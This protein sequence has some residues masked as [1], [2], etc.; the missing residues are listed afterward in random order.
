MFNCSAD[1]PMKTSRC[2]KAR[3][4]KLALLCTVCSLL[5]HVIAVVFVA[6]GSQVK[7][8][9]QVVEVAGS[10]PQAAEVSETANLSCTNI[11]EFHEFY[12]RTAWIS[13]A[14]IESWSNAAFSFQSWC[15]S[16]QQ[17]G[18][19][20]GLGDKRSQFSR[21]KGRLWKTRKR[22]DRDGQHSAFPKCMLCLGSQRQASAV[23]VL[24]QISRHHH[25]SIPSSTCS[26]FWKEALGRSNIYAMG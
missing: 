12:E 19:A 8:C 9:Q 4:W 15:R 21:E 13:I 6:F 3:S 24:L 18:W 11:H 17:C 16:T 1:P 14:S 22:M 25:P 5:L 20:E 26:F 23:S 10:H 2:S 7:A